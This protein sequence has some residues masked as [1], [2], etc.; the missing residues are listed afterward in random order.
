[1]KSM[2]RVLKLLLIFVAALVAL[3]VIA[4]LVFAL[5][6]DPND[7]RDRIAQAVEAQT[8]REFVIEGELGLSVFPWLAVEV[9]RT[10][11]GNAE[12]FGPEPF[13]SFESAEL[14][15]RL[16]PMLLRREIEVGKARLEGLD[17]QLAV[18]ADGRSNWQDLTE[19]QE[20]PD[21]AAPDEDDGGPAS[22]DI[23]SIEVV[24][25]SLTYADAQAGTTYRLQNL[26]ASTGTIRPGDPVD[27]DAGFDFAMEP[28]GTTGSLDA[29]GTLT[30]GES[31]VDLADVSVQGELA[32]ETPVHLELAM[33]IVQ[34]NTG[35]G[36]LKVANVTIKGDVGGETPLEFDLAAAA[37]EMDTE[38]GSLTVANL[39]SRG[40]LAG[41]TPVAFSLSAP[42]IGVDTEASRVSPGTLDFSA[43]DVKGNAA[44]EPF[45]YADEITPSATL[46]IDAFS[47]KSLMQALDIEAPPTADPDALG[48]LVIDAHAAVG[49][50]SITLD[51]L[52]MKLDDTTFTGEFVMPMDPAGRI[53]FGLAADAINADRY[54]APTD[55][56]AAP[57][58]DGEEPPLEIPVDLIRE[59][60]V[61]GSL[62]IGEV[63]LGGMSFSDVELV[64]DSAD[65]RMRIHPFTAGFFDGRYEGD[66]R[67]DASGDL[68]SLSA[69]EKISDVSLAPLAKAAFEQ[70][71]IT[72]L[73]NGTFQL[74]GRGNDMSEIQKTLDGKLS[75][76][77]ADGAY[78]GVDVWY[79][80]RRARALFRK[81]APPE[82]S[83]PPRTAFSDVSATGT[84]TDGVMRNEDFV[85]DLPFMRLTGK[86][87]VD[88]VAGT[89]DYALTGN[90]YDRP[91]GIGQ[92][93][94][95]EVADLAKAVIPLKVT[96]SL[97]E[98]KIGID[99]D[100]MVKERAKDELRERLLEKLDDGEE[101]TG[102]GE[103]E[104]KDPED[105]AKDL[106][107]DKLRDLLDQ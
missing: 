59:L 88:L 39:S 101:T 2:G 79:Q 24:N 14:S 25:A 31:T 94:Q 76:A 15:V 87:S 30:L 44:V 56:N 22:L 3:A 83:L 81:E 96:G 48:K 98:P 77:L 4:V 49:I 107:K 29:A 58:A 72:G 9:G 92:T 71:N 7:Y 36:A 82:P 12:G 78:E 68:A 13:A 69:N 62:T 28:D 70:E 35:S 45:S 47:P 27:F 8:G 102:E 104:E 10:K 46:H 16:L 105:E 64:V 52:R 51:Q 43:F 38:A 20:T 6:F 57:A 55:E 86:G 89:I 103:T 93:A 11:L 90:V 67:I 99:V 26:N 32:G 95:G 80:L 66:I 65:G 19:A 5:L 18:A 75:F 73:L 100:D 42:A 34:M 41:E 50:D 91:E 63:L 1:M 106:L 53:R 85:A 40:Q 37:V 23:G 74:S 21:P 54:M 60:N 17:L 33:P 61:A 97:V 84:V